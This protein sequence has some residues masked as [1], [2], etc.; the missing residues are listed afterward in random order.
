MKFIDLKPLSI[1]RLKTYRKS[2]NAKVGGF[3]VCDCGSM[4]CDHAR[5]LAK[6][7]PNYVNLRAVLDRV[8]AELAN[9]QQKL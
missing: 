7:N 4:G 2:L 8:N 9:K 3:E 5:T 1:K 6:Q